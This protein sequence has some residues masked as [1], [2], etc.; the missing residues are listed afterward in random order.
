MSLVDIAFPYRRKRSF[1][2]ASFALTFLVL[3][4]EVEALVFV[5]VVLVARQLQM[6]WDLQHLVFPVAC[7]ISLSA[8]AVFWWRARAWSKERIAT[9]NAWA[10]GGTTFGQQLAQKRDR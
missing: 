7:L 10:R 2:A 5:G 8:T 1:G 3:L 9:L 4:F 6:W